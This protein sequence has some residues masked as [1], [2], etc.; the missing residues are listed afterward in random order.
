[1]VDWAFPVAAPE[2]DQHQK[3]LIREWQL[4]TDNKLREVMLSRLLVQLRTWRPDVLIIDEPPADDAT[5]SLLAD[6]LR[7]AVVDAAT[8]SSQ[9]PYKTALHLPT[10]QIKRAYRRLPAGS[11]GDDAVDAFELL[12]RLGS[13]VVMAAAGPIGLLGE[14]TI[15]EAQR[16]G[17]A[18][19]PL[20]G[21]QSEAG[22]GDLFA[23]LVLQ[24]G[25]D[26]RRRLDVGRHERGAD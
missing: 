25:S 17:Y 21:L 20:A 23:G 16:E 3:E 19:W 10:W 7:L 14:P 22:G 24:P 18:L 1:M 2:L 9:D 15:T 26:A 4:L 11:E 5:T 6:A 13:S 12:P 8:E